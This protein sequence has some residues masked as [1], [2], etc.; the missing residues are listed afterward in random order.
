VPFVLADSPQGGRPPGRRRTSLIL[1]ALALA[2]VIAWTVQ[3]RPGEVGAAQ[4]AR[5]AT[6]GLS[7]AAV[8]EVVH[9]FRTAVV[10]GDV[11]AA[12][13]LGADARARR[14]LR[15][16]VRNAVELQLREFSARHVR[17]APRS[18]DDS[19]AV[20]L[21]VEW[22]LD[23]YDAGPSV[24]EVLLRLAPQG[25][26]LSIAG[27]GGTGSVRTPLWLSAPVHVARSARVLVL[28][29]GSAQVAQREHARARRALAEV[30][31]IR[32]RWRERVVIEVAASTDS[33]AAAIGAEPG[34]HARTA[35]VVAPAGERR[36]PPAPVHV[37]VNGALAPAQRAGEASAQVVTTHEIVHLATR[38]GEEY[39][40]AWLLEGFADLVALRDVELDTRTAAGVIHAVRTRGLPRD[41]PAA[42]E[43]ASA[44]TSASGGAQAAYEA[45]WVACRVAE[46]RLGLPALVALHHDVRSG[47]GV[48]EALRQAG[49]SR[50]GLVRAWRREL[51]ALAG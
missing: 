23:G 11:R 30:R 26:R 41:L 17:Q 10:D 2:A 36:T 37:F 46:R 7:E 32:P 27:L 14:Q 18:T 40:P 19:P 22:Q 51:A 13:R 38:E 6:P 34:P 8:A 24:A 48:A 42:A 12:S 25:G 45:A 33:F 49:W 35:A 28:A 44:S 9:A 20:V 16:L 4:D 43:L 31:G 29:E 3:S 50:Q 39:L 47:Q 5:P 15:S 1:L 21:E